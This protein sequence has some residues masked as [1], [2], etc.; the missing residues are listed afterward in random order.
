MSAQATHVA[1]L[2][3]GWSAER[4]VSL[5]TGAAV[6]R[7]LEKSG[8]HVT[9]VDVTRAL[10]QALAEIGPDVVLSV[11]KSLQSFFSSK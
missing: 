11:V 5:V 7:A 8:Y 3:G 10:P 4:E 9:G 1:L 2:K 6:E